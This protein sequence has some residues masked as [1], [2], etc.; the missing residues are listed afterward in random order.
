MKKFFEKHSNI[1]KKAG[2]LALAALI[3]GTGAVTYHNSVK[4]DVPELVT[5]TD[6]EA[7]TA[8]EDEVPLASGTKTTKKTTT[9]T[10]TKKTKMKTK[11]K[12]S[13]TST[14]K[15]TKNTNKT[16]KTS[17][18]QIKTNTKVVTT[19]KTSTKKNSKIK[20][21]Q[22]KVVTT[23]TTT[24]TTLPKTTASTAS[25]T[26]SSTAAVNTASTY[27]V[28][29]VATGCDSRVLNA[30]D[31]MGCKVV[32]NPT[33]AYAG[34]F[35]ASKRTITLKKLDNTIYHELGHF[36]EFVGGT[37]TVKTAITNAYNTEKS[38]YTAYDKAYVTQNSSEYFAESFKNYCE[39]AELLRQQRPNTYNAVV[40]ALNNITD[41]RVNMLISVYSSVWS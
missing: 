1:W 38:L 23:V 3:A 22:T 37:S 39:N 8:V 33:V 12:K 14:K 18:Q 2:C 36:V 26:T 10:T 5:Y 27:S 21:T 35:D 13:A 25:K 6:P 34:C 41:A 30:F 15:T 9:K 4:E 29:T 19:I 20:T 16:Q 11:A 31:K 7:V 17:A 24:T 28:K 32:V 40:A